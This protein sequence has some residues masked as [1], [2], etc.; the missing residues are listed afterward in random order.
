MYPI[1][2]EWCPYKKG[3]FRHRNKAREHH[4]KTEDWNDASASQGTAKVASKPP[5]AGKRKG[6][7]PLQVSKRSW[8]C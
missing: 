7:I 5:E 6:R 8:L 4:V 3:T 1:Q 2:Y